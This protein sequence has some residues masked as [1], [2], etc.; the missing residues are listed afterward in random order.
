MRYL[1]VIAFICLAAVRMAAQQTPPLPKITPVIQSVMNGKNASVEMTVSTPEDIVIVITDSTGNTIYLE[2]LH[3]Y[4]GRF[5]R[6]VD[7]PARGKY[8]VAI[9]RE[10][11]KIKQVLDAK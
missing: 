10:G 11:E 4:T 5:K 2:N 3:R 9:N 1:S 6:L 8:T 7:L